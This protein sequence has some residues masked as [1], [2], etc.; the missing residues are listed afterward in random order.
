ME[1]KLVN[2]S[3]SDWAANEARKKQ[4]L[5][6]GKTELKTVVS[7]LFVLHF[8][9]SFSPLHTYILRLITQLVEYSIDNTIEKW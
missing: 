3:L 6:S 8:N 4:A 1:I 7:I 5:R 9:Q 2:A